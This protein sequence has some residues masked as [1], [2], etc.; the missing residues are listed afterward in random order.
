MVSYISCN[1]EDKKNA[2][3]FRGITFLIVQKLNNDS[4]DI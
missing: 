1:I 4:Y 3:C 2:E